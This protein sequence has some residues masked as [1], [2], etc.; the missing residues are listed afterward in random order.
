MNYKLLNFQRIFGNLTIGS[1]T[2]KCIILYFTLI[3][4]GCSVIE[5]SRW[6]SSISTNTRVNIDKPQTVEYVDFCATLKK[7]W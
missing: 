6:E 2:I 3:S 5:E 7:S 1:K 4:A